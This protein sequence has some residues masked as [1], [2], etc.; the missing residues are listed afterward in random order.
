M[1]EQFK[2]RVWHKLGN[3][4]LKNPLIMFSP[5]DDGFI[6]CQ[7][8]THGHNYGAGPFSNS[9]IYTSENIV[10]QQFTGLKDK[11][12]KDIYEGD[13]VTFTE[14]GIPGTWAH[15][16]L[17]GGVRIVKWSLEAGGDYPF[18]GFTFIKYDTGDFDI[19]VLVDCINIQYCEVVGNIFENPELI[20]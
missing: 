19:G 14:C 1:N 5:E 8:S 13:I 16:Y 20:K 4:F 18:A 7:T 15:N 6:M 2:F 3:E 9:Q 10:I 11:N 12:G 17:N